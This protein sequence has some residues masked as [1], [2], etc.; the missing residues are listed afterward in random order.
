MIKRGDIYFISRD[1]NEVGNEERCGRPAV[2]I[3]SDEINEEGFGAVVVLM[4]SSP[5]RKNYPYHCEVQSFNGRQSIV[6]CDTVR[7]V[8]ANRIGSYAGHLSDEDLAKVEYIL[9]L[10]LD[11]PIGTEL[12]DEES[13]R[14][15]EDEQTIANLKQSIE[16]LNNKVAVLAKLNRHLTDMLVGD[17]D[18]E[19]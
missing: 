1:Y 13:D 6:L 5:N 16:I 8:S 12:T 14:F 17:T 15:A 2:V 11:L 9:S 19:V 18:A 7:Y 4:S 10:A 3:S